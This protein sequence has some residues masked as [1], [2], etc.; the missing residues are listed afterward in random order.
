V[1]LAGSAIPLGPL[2]GEYVLSVIQGSGQ[3]TA[4]NNAD[5]DL[6]ARIGFTYDKNLFVGA[7]GYDGT[8]ENG[9][10]WDLGLEAKWV[11]N[12]LKLQGEFITGSVN[13]N[14]NSSAN[15]SVWTP[16]LPTIPF[17]GKNVIPNTNFVIPSGQLLPTAYYLTAS[18]RLGDV[19]LGGRFDGYN[20]DQADG[21]IA[22]QAAWNTELDTITIGLDWFQDKDALKWSANFEDHVV[23][24]TDAYQVYTVQSQLYI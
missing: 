11:Y 4:D 1:Q 9:T 15:D 10:R 21:L 14:D 24:S 16:S 7:S 17:G 6:A 13:T 5:K 20:F 18:Y 22:S 19:R 12:G 23:G 3:S 2:Q 8:E